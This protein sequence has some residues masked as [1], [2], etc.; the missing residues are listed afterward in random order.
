MAY[1]ARDK[2]VA[3]NYTLRHSPITLGRDARNDI[4]LDSD[5]RASRAHAEIEQ[6]FDGWI[7]RDLQS[8]NGTFANGRR[9]T[10]HTLRGGDA[11][12]VGGTTLMFCAG[13]DP[14]ETAA[15]EGARQPRPLRPAPSLSGREREILALVAS[16]ATNH[17]IAAA[18]FISAATVRSHLDRIRDKTG[19]RR[20][21][22]LTRLAVQLRLL[23]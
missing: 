15:D 6:R 13:D 1:L 7:L 9:I 23:D 4:V 22:E 21:P 2:A 10:E 3:P 16:G 17:Q 11:I 8:R 18:L 20:R 19:C 5:M 14:F 12:R